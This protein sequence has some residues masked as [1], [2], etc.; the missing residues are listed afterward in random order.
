[1]LNLTLMPIVRRFWAAVLLEVA[2]IGG[3]D[4]QELGVVE[5]QPGQAGV[6]AKAETG[7]GVIAQEDLGGA[8]R[9]WEI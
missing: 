1:M 2:V 8:G 5:Y 9:G 6:V 3:A 7:A 4:R